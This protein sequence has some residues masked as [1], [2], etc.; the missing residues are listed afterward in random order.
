M[1]IQLNTFVAFGCFV[2]I[3]K[4]L[5]KEEKLRQMWY[6]LWCRNIIWKFD[7]E[8]FRSCKIIAKVQTGGPTDGRAKRYLYIAFCSKSCEFVSIC[9]Y[10]FSSC[11]QSLGIITRA[12]WCCAVSLQVY[13]SNIFKTN[14]HPIYICVQYFYSG[15]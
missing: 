4:K 6:L 5:T 1:G 11:S 9:I 2:R 3:T 15:R 13:L 7:G 12:L 8:K 10:I 14:L